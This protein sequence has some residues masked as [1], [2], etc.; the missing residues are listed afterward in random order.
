M[1]IKQLVCITKQAIMKF[2]W[3]N[4]MCQ[5]SIPQWLILD[6]MQQ[7]QG[8]KIQEWCREFKI[9]HVFTSMAY[10]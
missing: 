8:N 6:N 3:Q 9:E 5:Y 2:L 7:F 4:I 10:P 1:E